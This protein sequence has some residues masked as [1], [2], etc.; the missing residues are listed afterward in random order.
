VTVSGPAD[1]D[2]M[3][4][5]QGCLAQQ[6]ATFVACAE[7][8]GVPAD[9]R[10]GFPRGV[11][12]GVA[13][14]AAVIAGIGGGPTPAY[15]DEYERA[16]ALLNELA[17]LAAEFLQARGHRA[18]PLRATVKTL[19]KA[20][21]ATPLPHKTTARLA[22][23]GWIGKCALLITR[24]HGSAVRY[25]TVLTEAPLPAGMPAD[26]SECGACTACVDACPP[27]ALLGRSWQPGMKREELLDALVCCNDAQRR[28]AA[29]EIDNVIC[30][31]CIAACPHTKR[32][33]ARSEPTEAIQPEQ[34]TETS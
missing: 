4:S 23:L 5:L 21:L 31:I 6:G 16:N 2:L 20:T 15:A 1:A 34:E 19:D 30:G 12:I 11:A 14:D 13:L 32:Y 18:V 28:A 10:Q 25:N 3:A 22:G 7:L 27:G 24:S 8:R 26:V 29:F 9:A 33:V 17:R